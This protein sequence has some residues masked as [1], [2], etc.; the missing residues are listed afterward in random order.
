MQEE[1]REAARKRKPKAAWALAQWFE[2][3]ERRTEE[4]AG[5][6]GDAGLEDDQ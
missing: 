6:W 3:R 2:A 1:P 4:L 5:V